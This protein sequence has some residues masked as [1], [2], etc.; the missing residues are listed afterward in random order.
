MLTKKE[1]FSLRDIELVS[2]RRLGDIVNIPVSEIDQI[3]VPYRKDY[4]LT[5][6]LVGLGIDAL[7]VYWWSYSDPLG[8][9]M[10]FGILSKF[11]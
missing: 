5:G 2:I 4:A 6:F 8:G 7:I 3:I 1:E 9:S 11:I 10:G